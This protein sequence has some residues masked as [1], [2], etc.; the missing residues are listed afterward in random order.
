MLRQR[1]PIANLN[2]PFGACQ[3]KP[4]HQRGVTSKQST[5]MR[6]APTARTREKSWTR[7]LKSRRTRWTNW[8]LGRRRWPTT[9]QGIMDTSRKLIWTLKH[10]CRASANNQ[11]QRLSSKISLRTTKLK[12]RDTQGTSQWAFWMTAALSDHNVWPHKEKR[13][14]DIFNKF[15]IKMCDKFKYSLSSNQIPFVVLL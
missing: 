15:N 11:E 9:F 12:C 7:T 8:A 3:E 5:E 2:D 14:A 6:W 4:T 10:W 1:K 13:S